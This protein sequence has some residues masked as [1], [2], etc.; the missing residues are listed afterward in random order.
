M[1][2]HP[3]VT[4]HIMGMNAETV[5]TLAREMREALEQRQVKVIHLARRR[6][7]AGPVEQD[8]ARIQGEVQAELEREGA[9]GDDDF[10]AEAELCSELEGLDA[11]GARRR[12]LGFR[13][14]ARARRRAPRDVRARLR[15]G[16]GEGL[17]DELE[18]QIAAELDDEDAA[19]AASVRPPRAGFRDGSC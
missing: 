2:T 1:R 14:R 9:A 16:T 3:A 4:D 18:A 10:D 15:R 5:A 19:K 7:S 8:R 6:I 12:A 13:A 17:D 11:D